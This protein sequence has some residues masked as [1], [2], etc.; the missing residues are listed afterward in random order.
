MFLNWIIISAIC[1]V[2]THWGCVNTRDLRVNDHSDPIR[3]IGNRWKRILKAGLMNRTHY[4]ILYLR[5]ERRNEI[6]PT[7][8]WLM[9]RMMSACLPGGLLSHRNEQNEE[10]ET[11]HSPWCHQTVPGRP[12]RLFTEEK[13][14][15]QHADGHGDAMLEWSVFWDHVIGPCNPILYPTPPPHTTSSACHY[16]FMCF[17]KLRERDRGGKKE[18]S[19]N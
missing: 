13:A 7:S 9:R 4:V 1:N 5:C 19:P 6:I 15:S 8:I 16:I 11:R 10:K 14:Q 12:A 2:Q 3:P 17:V 18:V